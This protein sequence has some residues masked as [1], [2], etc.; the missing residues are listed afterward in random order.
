MVSHSAGEAN[1]NKNMSGIPSVE[2][3]DG[4]AVRGGS[5]SYRNVKVLGTYCNYEVAKKTQEYRRGS[6]N[7][8]LR[9][10]FKF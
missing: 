9:E 6:S 10:T 4:V 8:L 3:I 7:V 2:Q 1:I 5:S